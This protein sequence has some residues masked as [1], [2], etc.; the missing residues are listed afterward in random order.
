MIIFLYGADNFR[1]WKKTLEI[2]E[3][4][5]KIHPR[6]LNFLDFDLKEMNFND[7]KRNLDATSIFKE[8]KLVLVKNLFSS[9]ETVRL[10]LDYL[11]S[12]KIFESKENIIVIYENYPFFQEV[13]GKKVSILKDEKKELFDKLIK[14]SKS[15]EFECLDDSKIRIWVAK[16]FSKKN[17]Q[18]SL[19]AL[20]KL[21]YWV[22]NDLWRM[23]NEIKKLSLVGKRT[24]EEKDINTLVRSKIETNIFKIIEAVSS[25]NKKAAM[26]LITEYQEKGE[27]E[28][29]LLSMILWQI[30]NIA[31]VKFSKFNEEYPSFSTKQKIAK[32]LKIHPYVV[33]KS[34]ALAKK[35]S[36]EEIKKVYH[37]LMEVDYKIKTGKI[38]SGAALILFVSEIC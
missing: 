24:I 8:K 30:R 25:R 20:K 3:K 18:I 28:E 31:Q 2:V 35:F 33:E 37:K 21:I 1:S 10:F 12:S 15:Q 32:E 17:V 4:Y 22:G 7:F 36:G 5:K 13:K 19:L 11:K 27:S 9:Q 14:L 38:E 16:E 23:E 34:L 26:R 29:Y 6:G